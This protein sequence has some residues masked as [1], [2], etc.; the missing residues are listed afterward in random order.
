M[1]GRRGDF[2]YVGLIAFAVA[3]GWLGVQLFGSGSGRPFSQGDLAAMF[4]E[5]ELPP[6]DLAELDFGLFR[7]AKRYA[8]IRAQV[9]YAD[10]ME[11]ALVQNRNAL[12]TTAPPPLHETP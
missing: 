7:P 10:E 11:L 9:R 1:A 5:V 12:L 4:R 2:F 8:P 3:A 6:I